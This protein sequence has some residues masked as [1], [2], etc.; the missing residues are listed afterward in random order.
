LTEGRSAAWR[1]GGRR[2]EGEGTQKADGRV[3]K[4]KDVCP[5]NVGSWIGVGAGIEEDTGT[6]FDDIV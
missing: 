6:K 2:S 5:G 4:R 1:I 3:K